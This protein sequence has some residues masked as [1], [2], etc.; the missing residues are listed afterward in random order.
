VDGG[1]QAGSTPGFSYTITSA[2]ASVLCWDANVSSTV[3][4]PPPRRRRARTRWGRCSRPAAAAGAPH[5]HGAHDHHQLVD[6]HDPGHHDHDR[7]YDHHDRTYDYD[8]HGEW[9]GPVTT[10]MIDLTGGVLLEVT[11]STQAWYYPNLQGGT[12]A[13]ASSAGTAV[14][15]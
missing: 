7:A 6:Y 4:P 1:G 13:E 11:G 3:S 5:D 14:G 2:E 10:Y 12:A 9:L 8:D 15:G